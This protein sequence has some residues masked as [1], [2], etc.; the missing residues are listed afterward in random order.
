MKLWD[1]HHNS[2]IGGIGHIA[3]QKRAKVASVFCRPGIRKPMKA[4]L[5]IPDIPESFTVDHKQDSLVIHFPMKPED[6][7]LRELKS[8]I[9]EAIVFRSINEVGLDFQGQSVEVDCFQIIVQ[10]AQMMKILHK[11][12]SV[13]S[14]TPEFLHSL[15]A[16]GLA[17][18]IRIRAGEGDVC[19]LGGKASIATFPAETRILMVD[20]VQ[21]VRN[22]MRAFLGELGY[23]NIQEAATG[24]DALKRMEEAASSGSPFQVVIS[25]WYM[26]GMNGLQLFRALREKTHLGKFDFILL[27]VETEKAN[28]L[29]AR[30]EGVKNYL[31]KP[32]RQETIREKFHEIWARETQGK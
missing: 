15:S 26:P 32:F 23:V 4:A 9:A 6:W 7:N 18:L 14:P 8:I 11:Q 2:H 24:D 1:L 16:N 13:W 10:A 17:D 29:K 19:E 31:V 22:L 27:T 20:D 25:D 5:K 12:L 28:V 21:S 30:Q 3:P